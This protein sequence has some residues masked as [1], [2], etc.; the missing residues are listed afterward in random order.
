MNNFPSPRT[1][2]HP[3]GLFKGFPVGVTACDGPFFNI[4]LNYESETKT[5]LDYW[6]SQKYS[7]PSPTKIK[8]LNDTIKHLKIRGIWS[9]LDIL[10]LFATDGD[11]NCAFTNL[12][13]PSQ[14][15]AG[16][17]VGVGGGSDSQQPS[18]NGVY[19]ISSGSIPGVPLGLS[20]NFN[21]AT[22]AVKAT[23]NDNS[24]FGYIYPSAK[25]NAGVDN[26]DLCGNANAVGGFLLSYFGVN[27]FFWLQNETPASGT[28]T[29][30]QN[31][32]FMFHGQRISSATKQFYYNGV[33]PS[34]VAATS[35]AFNSSNLVI[36]RNLGGGGQVWNTYCPFFGFGASLTGLEQN[37][38]N[39]MMKYI[40]NVI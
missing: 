14:F 13:S 26:G 22:N 3:T 10:Y 39:I 23:Q 18:Y 8:L 21:P 36:T 12:I 33:G 20:T 11:I 40:N 31:T 35:A 38:Y 17:F 16:L 19:G 4:G 32:P 29:R 15:K 9:Q 34:Q 7:L 37:L 6:F 5:V 30:R 1:E 25:G 2:I 28:G 24:M 27:T